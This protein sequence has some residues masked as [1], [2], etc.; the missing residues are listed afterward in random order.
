[1]IRERIELCK[2]MKK[3]KSSQT[4]ILVLDW[5]KHSFNM[6]VSLRQIEWW[7]QNG[8]I[9]KNEILPVTTLFFWKFCFSLRTSYKRLIWCTNDTNIHIRTFF[10]DWSFIWRCFFPVFILKK[11]CSEIQEMSLFSKLILLTT[12]EHL[13]D[14]LMCFF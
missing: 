7:V 2:C 10:K 9:T 11:Q 1:M 8:P 5:V 3:V 14:T 6:W 13:T 4:A 12:Q